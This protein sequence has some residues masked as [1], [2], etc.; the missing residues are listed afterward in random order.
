MKDHPNSNADKVENI[1]FIENFTTYQYDNLER[2]LIILIDDIKIKNV[3]EMNFDSIQVHELD[4]LIEQ[5]NLTP[6]L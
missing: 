6:S 2:D 5:D 4:D 3:F 1:N